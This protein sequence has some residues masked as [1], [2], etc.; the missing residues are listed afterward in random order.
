M[1]ISFLYHHFQITIATVATIVA[2]VSYARY[3]HKGSDY[4]QPSMMHF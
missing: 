1:A 2:S 4:L 3:S